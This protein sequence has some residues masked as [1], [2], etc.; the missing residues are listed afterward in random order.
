MKDYIPK[1]QTV[2]LD[3]HGCESVHISTTAIR[4]FFQGQLVWDGDVETFA[5]KNHPQAS[6][7]YA[8]AYQGDDGQEHYT[9]VLELPPVSSPQSAVKAALVAQVK[10]ERKET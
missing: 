7:C 8:W 2:I 1:L 5:I 4:E 3:L 6:R 9:A 10:N